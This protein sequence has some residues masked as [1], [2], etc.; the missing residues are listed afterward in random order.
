MLQYWAFSRCN[1]GG[2]EGWGGPRKYPR[3]SYEMDA[4]KTVHTLAGGRGLEG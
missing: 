1:M 2:W 4:A 3:P